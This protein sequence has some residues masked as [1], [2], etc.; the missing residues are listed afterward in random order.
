[1]LAL[2]K[3][4][5]IGWKILTCLVSD[6]RLVGGI[7]CEMCLNAEMTA[8]EPLSLPEE[9]KMQEDWI[10]DERSKACSVLGT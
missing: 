4:I 8:S 5:I 7:V 9:Y 2:W 1:M 10:T 6:F 3:Y